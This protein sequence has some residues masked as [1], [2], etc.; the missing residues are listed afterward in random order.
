MTRT[1]PATDG[2]LEAVR[3]CFADSRKVIASKWLL[4]DAGARLFDAICQAPDYYI[5]HAE[6]EILE[7]AISSIQDLAGPGAW[8]VQLGL[9]ERSKATILLDRLQKVQGFVPIDLQTD[10]IDEMAATLRS[11]YPE[12]VVSPLPQDFSTGL[13]LPPWLE[14]KHL[15][16]FMP[17]GTLCSY[18]RQEMVMLL[19][20]LSEAVPPGTGLLVGV[21][22]KKGRSVFERA[23]NSPEMRAFNL[24]LIDRINSELGGDL[25]P[26]AF[27]H[28]ALYNPQRERVEV[29]VV[30]KRA[31]MVSIAGQRFRLAA[32][33]RI[34]TERSHKYEVTEFQ[35]VAARS[36]WQVMNSFVDEERLFSLHFL[37]SGR[38]ATSSEPVEG[39]DLARP[40]ALPI[41]HRLAHRLGAILRARR[42]LAAVDD[43]GCARLV[44]AIGLG[45]VGGR[46]L[47][48]QAEA[49]GGVGKGDDCGPGHDQALL[50]AGEAQGHGE[51][52]RIGLQAPELVLQHDRH[53]V[54]IARL[55]VVG[56][57]H[58][59]RRRAEGDVEVML[60]RQAALGD[61]AQRLPQDTAQCALEHMVIA[62]GVAALV[63]H[64]HRPI[65]FQLALCA[66]R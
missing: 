20:R 55:K 56:D 61:L 6:Q 45:L 48:L 4:D 7:S 31:Q 63:L 35:F 32:G 15:L 21:D 2:F 30:S 14:D 40:R 53:L 60:A 24:N 16:L 44:I 13:T 1:R 3:N 27:E 9:D 25:D 57:L 58:T 62:K 38:D 47:E 5:A 33:E 51:A 12:L 50:P 34:Q 17:G 59:R 28:E 49:H 41:L 36:N 10:R 19:E 52:L 23:Y 64:R 29:Y 37:R 46:G 43:G 54:R 66:P 65:L 8:L 26:E 42:M 22:L 11:R 39:D 18:T